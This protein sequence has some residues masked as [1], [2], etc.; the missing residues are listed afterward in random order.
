MSSA[1]M[2][3]ILKNEN[4]IEYKSSIRYG[5]SLYSYL[6]PPVHHIYTRDK[7]DGSLSLI[8]QYL[9]TKNTE[10]EETCILKLKRNEIEVNLRIL[11]CCI[12]PFVF[13]QD[14]TDLLK[15]LHRANTAY[16]FERSNFI[17]Q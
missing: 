4:E 2:K 14:K 6:G 17:N 3:V 12:P 11:N 16:Q 1:A 15:L 10:T 5:S 7:E 9:K 13:V 8:I